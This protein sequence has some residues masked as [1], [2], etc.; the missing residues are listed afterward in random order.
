MKK[1]IFL[2]VLIFTT[3]LFA[4]IQMNYKEIYKHSAPSVVLL[5]GVSGKV[6][7][8]GTGS[9]I[10]EDGTII[11][12][13]H[14]VINPA[15]HKPFDA[16]YAFLKPKRVN[17]KNANDLKHR[18]KAHVLKFDE[19]MDLA[20][21]KIENPPADLPVMVVADTSEITPGEPTVA[22]GHPEQGSR[23]SLTTG[24]ISSQIDDFNGIKG[25]HVFQMET[26][27]N[28]GNSGGPLLDYRGYLIGVNSMIARESKDGLAIVGIN[29]AIKA[30]A[31]VDWMA[32]NGFYISIAN[33]SGQEVETYVEQPKMAQKA[34]PQYK[35][36]PHHPKKEVKMEVRVEKPHQE[37]TQPIS[38]K[39]VI[40]RRIR[41]KSKR[42]YKKRP[43]KA[44]VIAKSKPGQIFS[45]K[46]VVKQ[47]KR[48]AINRMHDKLGDWDEEVPGFEDNDTF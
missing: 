39:V 27:V 2:V 21:V 13:A 5:F 32:R 15:N 25:K 18:Y 3:P 40:K 37:R 36:Q 38:N 47:R 42:H 30:D 28:R 41:V 34:E 6:G 19:A 1:I 26:A 9:I 7:S 24:A 45:E 4:Q 23:W 43:K 48:K 31:V 46:D 22:I 44:R 10:K 14:V 11:T 35:P 12:N 29:F 33:N 8:S 20:V 16:L 17:G